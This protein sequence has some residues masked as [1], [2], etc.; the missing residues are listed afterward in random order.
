MICDG[1]LYV[2]VVMIGGVGSG[3]QAAG[4]VV[5]LSHAWATPGPQMRNSRPRLWVCELR[6]AMRVPFPKS[7]VRQYSTSWNGGT[8]W[9]KM[10]AAS[11]TPRNG[12]LRSV[13]NHRFSHCWFSIGTSKTL[14]ACEFHTMVPSTG[15]SE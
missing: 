11:E 9:M 7:V 15:S 5:V 6:S 4:L 1:S 8:F 3:R 2:V 13:V 12:Y 10:S 14:K